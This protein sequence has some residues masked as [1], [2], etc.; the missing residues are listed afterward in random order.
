MIALLFL[1]GY[2]GAF[3][4]RYGVPLIGYAALWL[5]RCFR[6]ALRIAIRVL[7]AGR[8]TA[9]N[10][11]TDEAAQD[12]EDEQSAFSDADAYQAAYDAARNILGLPETFTDKDLNLAY[13]RMI[14]RAHPDRGGST[15]LAQVVNTARDVIRRADRHRSAP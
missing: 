9:V 5:L 13:R 11:S 12:G 15:E 1:W 7:S 4:L 3:F 8:F 10:S 14:S 2:G 6:L